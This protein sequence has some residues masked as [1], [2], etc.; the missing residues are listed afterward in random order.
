M[1]FHLKE[2]M[3]CWIQREVP[4][5]GSLE[6]LVS[7]MEQAGFREVAQKGSTRRFKRGAAV[8]GTF[9]YD[10]EALEVQVHLTPQSDGSVRLKVGNY[11]F[12]L[13]P[14]LMKRRFERLCARLAT[15]I[16]ERGV[17]TIEPG[18]A[19][20]A[21]A[22]ASKAKSVVIGAAVT[23]SFYLLAKLILRALL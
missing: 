22:Q 3:S 23:L 7:S 16:Q 12:P 13:E 5:E 18:E 20:A 2:I 14:L 9:D 15:D 1:A 4:F 6:A 8:G 10:G 11:G 19:E 17:L 21:Q